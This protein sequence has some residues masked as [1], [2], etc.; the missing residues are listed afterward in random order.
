MGPDLPAGTDVIQLEIAVSLYENITQSVNLRH[1]TNATY[2]IDEFREM[3]GVPTGRYPVY[4][5]LNRHV[6]KPSVTEINALAH[7]EISVLPIKKGKKVDQIMIAWT[8]K[9]DE[10]HHEALRERERPRVGRRARLNNRVEHRQR[11]A[12]DRSHDAGQYA[13]AALPKSLIVGRCRRYPGSSA[14]CG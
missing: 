11:D 1:I 4:G 7:F 2:T 13:A 12:F 14:S 10:A 9:S 8:K 6:I 3:M 5:D